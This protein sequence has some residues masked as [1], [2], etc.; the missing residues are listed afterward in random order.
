MLPF[1]Q[2][3]EF[4][5][6]E[7]GVGDDAAKRAGAELLV[8]GNDGSGRRLATAQHHMAASLTAEDEPSALKGG[9]DFPAG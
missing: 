2:S 7:S 8:V 5:N 4:F 6:G 1:E 3:N 9:A